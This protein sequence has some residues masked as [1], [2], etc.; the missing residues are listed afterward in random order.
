[1]RYG[2]ANNKKDWYF[3][4]RKTRVAIVLSLIILVLG[5]ICIKLSPQEI[6]PDTSSPVVYVSATYN[7]ASSSIME[8]TVA[9]VI[10]AGLTG[11][12]NLEYMESNCSDG[13][14][15]LSIYFKAGSNKDV[16]LLNVKNQLQEIDFQL[17][18]E[19]QKEGISAITTSGEKGA[20]ILNLSSKND[21]WEQLD[22]ANYAKS[23]IVDRLKMVEGV[24]DC[25]LSGIGD[26][27]MRIW[28]DPQKMAA[29]G[30]TSGDI[31]YALNEQNGQFVIGTLGTPP[32]DTPQDIQMLIKADNLLSSVKD[33]ENV[34][35][36]SSSAHGQVLLKD[37]AKIELGSSDYSSYAMV[38]EKTTALIQ[39]IPTSG[40]NMV[41]LS[42][43]LNKK[44][45]QINKWLPKGLELNIIY[46]NATY[47]KEAINEVIGTIFITVIIVVLVILLFLGDFVSTLVPCVT[48]PISLIGAFGI[49]YIFH[50]T[51]NMLTLFALILAV[52]VVVDD[53]IVVV[54]NVSRHLQEGNSSKRATQVTMEEVGIT[55]VTMAVVLMTVFFPICFIPG[56]TGIL[57]K[58]FAIFLSSAIIISAVCALTLSPAMTSV[59]MQRNSDKEKFERG[60]LGL[61]SKCYHLF[62]TF[63]NKLSQLYTDCVKIFV[64][65][66][67]IT[68]VT[69]LCVLFLMIT[70][71]MIIPKA[72]VPDE[73]QG[74]LYG[75]VYMN[76]TS[77]IQKSKN[78]IKNI[79][80]K[81]QNVEGINIDKL[82]TIGYEDSATMYI[83][84]KDWKERHLNIAQKLSRKLTHKQN[85]LS[86]VGLQS[87]LMEKLS[88]DD[89]VYVNVSAPSALGAGSNN[90]FEFNLIS[91]GDYKH[92]DLTKYADKLV[93]A[94]RNNKKI[95]YAYNT[96]NG[97]I[98]IYVMHIDYK[99]AMALNIS[100][101]ELTSTLSSFIGS[102]NVSNFTKNGKN[103]EVRMQADGKFR[104][105]KQDLS[106][107][108]V[109]SNTGVMV[110][111]EAVISL[112]EVYSSSK[113]TRFNQSRS[114]CVI[115]QK[116]GN[117]SAGDAIKEI[118]RIAKEILPSDI[119]Y[120]WSGSSL[121]VIES[122]KQTTFIVA[123]ALLFIYFF[124]VALYN[125]WSI[126][127]VILIVSPVSIVGAMI[128]LLML[129]KPFDLYSQIGVITLIGLSAKQSILFV[130]FAMNQSEVN[131]LS[132]QNASILAAG[133]RFRAILMTEL[134]FLV[135]VI[136]ML[137]AIGPSANSRISLAAT[138][139]GGMLTTVSVGAILTPGFFSI[140]QTY[141]NK[142]PKA[143]EEEYYQENNEDLLNEETFF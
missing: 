67:K 106:K 109:R 142:L 32:L 36:K 53:A 57:Y 49:L 58:Q 104:R 139:F 45:G 21:S 52:S 86:S 92:E 10:E 129:G 62:N 136:P 31:N 103:Y 14:Y 69:Y 99:K 26:Y 54:E 121:Q 105:D 108:Y 15:S 3:F 61:W 46:D 17:P 141:L 2:Q 115:A 88:G 78:T 9:N 131:N 74:I 124:L 90:A 102:S 42:N 127:A 128:F 94:L 65:N 11:L 76:N 84:L 5:Y 30:V 66:P 98:P 95:S 56:F 64:Y 1:M 4:I 60:E 19:V 140:I 125:S 83:Q 44:V 38:G 7:G 97:A 28:L 107:L 47:M 100:I 119:G 48:I 12:D 40:A 132:P 16:N 123:L 138:V 114:I 134:S 20:I 133:M 51:I 122:A 35:I 34:V 126:P 130:E 68:I 113:I 112:E 70:V 80:G 24:A 59:L 37:V 118:E 55:L 71:F 72:F 101:H 120:E 82:L 77:T 8:T 22:L 29:L 143:A 93:E 50:M 33:F 25:V 89:D 110:P 137:F 39:I 91:M 63:F 117:V 81:I 79:I 85:D 27:S 75:T 116:Y 43:D 73:D 87:E 111:V 135:G 18:P 96:Y 23:N 13:Y 6:Y 41:K